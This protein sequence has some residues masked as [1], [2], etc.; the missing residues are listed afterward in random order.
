MASVHFAYSQSDGGRLPEAQWSQAP[1]KFRLLV[2]R[3]CYESDC[4]FDN[5]PR[6]VRA[7][8]YRKSE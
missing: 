6:S 2:D 1:R 7:P 5:S 4:V 3:E 8:E